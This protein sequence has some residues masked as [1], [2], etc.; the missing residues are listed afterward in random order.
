MRR[1]VVIVS[2]GRGIA[3]DDMV[4][5]QSGTRERCLVSSIARKAGYKRGA[6]V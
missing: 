6:S 5:G 1:S 3:G 2:L 4:R